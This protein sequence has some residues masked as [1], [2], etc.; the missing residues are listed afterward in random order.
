MKEYARWFYISNPWRKCRKAYLAANPLCERCLVKGII[1]PAKIIH[2]KR[3]ITPDNINNPD[4]TLSFDN[5]EAL[6]QDCHN[7]EHHGAEETFSYVFG[8]DGQIY[9]LPPSKSEDSSES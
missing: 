2:H 9:P 5:L 7:V 4:I 1:T 8:D 3:Y 6:C